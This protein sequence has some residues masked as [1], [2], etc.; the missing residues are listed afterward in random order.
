MLL[1]L[2]LVL[3]FVACLIRLVNF[4]RT[5]R[6]LERWS[7]TAR[8]QHEIPDETIAYAQKLGQLAQITGR[9]LPFNASCL[10]QSLSVWWLLRL[11]RVPAEL[12]IGVRNEGAFA[13]H[14]WVELGGRLVNESAD[15]RERFM[16]FDRV[17]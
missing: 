12:R 5:Y 6:L 11:K 4:R 15:T 13:A 10:R 2:A 14:A 1:W 17:Y 9:Y 3:T 7:P 8:I 16:A